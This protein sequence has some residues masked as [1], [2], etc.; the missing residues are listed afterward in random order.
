MNIVLLQEINQKKLGVGIKRCVKGKQ[1]EEMELEMNVVEII[2]KSD[3]IIA[4]KLVLEVSIV[5]L[6]TVY[7]TQGLNVQRIR[8]IH[9]GRTLMRLCKSYQK[10]RTS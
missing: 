2:K 7:V 3:R 9:F 8:E 1:I 10:R 5:S 4:V 6:I